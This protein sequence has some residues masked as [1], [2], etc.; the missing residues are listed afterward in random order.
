MSDAI[1][2]LDVALG[3]AE[4]AREM[5]LVRPTMND[6]YVSRLA[7][8]STRADTHRY[9]TSLVIEDGRHPTVEHSLKLDGRPFTTNSLC[10]SHPDAFVHCLTGPVSSPLCQSSIH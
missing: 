8:S 5:N 6:G 9:R 3:F 10:F 1:D 4:L 7:P 2:E